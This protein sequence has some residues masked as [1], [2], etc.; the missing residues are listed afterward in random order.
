MVSVSADISGIGLPPS[1]SSVISKV[2]IAVPTAIASPTFREV[3]VG[4]KVM[5]LI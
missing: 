4:E 2:G 5:S 1:V 3:E